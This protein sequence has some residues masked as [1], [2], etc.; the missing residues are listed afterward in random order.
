VPAAVQRGL[1]V[2]AHGRSAACAK[3][4][5]ARYTALWVLDCCEKGS[6]A[7]ASFDQAMID[8]IDNWRAKQKA[9]PNV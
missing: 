9:L 3:R 6:A 4:L 8:A 7:A 2:A 1:D 5:P